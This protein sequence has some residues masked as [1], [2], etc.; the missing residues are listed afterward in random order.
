MRITA[1][2]RKTYGLSLASTSDVNKLAACASVL[3]IITVGTPITSAANLAAINLST[4]S[5][6]GTK[7][8]PPDSH[9]KKK[10]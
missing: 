5:L 7:T 4:A 8:F 9:E 10:S 1:D 6:V 2:D 3:A